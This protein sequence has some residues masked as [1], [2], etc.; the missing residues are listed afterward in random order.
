MTEHAECSRCHR[1]LGTYD[2]SESFTSG[3][4]VVESGRWSRYANVGERF[5]CDACMWADPAYLAENP[6]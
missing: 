6:R 3:F 1:D 5:L 2:P 4:Y